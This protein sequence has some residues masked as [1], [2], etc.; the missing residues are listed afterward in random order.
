MFYG[1]IQNLGIPYSVYEQFK[2]DKTIFSKQIKINKN[3]LKTVYF[4][5]IRMF[6]DV[7]FRNAI[8]DVFTN[9]D[10]ARNRVQF[11]F[12]NEP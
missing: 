4:D 8:L 9:N 2:Q 3:I 6:E 12:S 7:E 1:Y 11:V 10:V 5:D